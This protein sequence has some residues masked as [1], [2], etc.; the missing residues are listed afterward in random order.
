MQTPAAADHAGMPEPEA[1]WIKSS[2]SFSNGNCVEVGRLPDG[3]IGVRHSQHREGPVL[4]F[5]P[6]EWTAF[7]AGVRNGEFDRFAEQ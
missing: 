2:F 6:G 4:R 7:L 3:H 5:A 1:Q